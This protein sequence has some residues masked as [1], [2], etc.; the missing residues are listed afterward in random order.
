MANCTSC[1]TKRPLIEISSWRQVGNQLVCPDCA[2]RNDKATADP[3]G[4]ARAA[5]AAGARLLQISLSLSQTTGHAVAMTGTN[6]TTTSTQHTSTLEAIEAEGW[7]LEHA[8]YVYRVTGS[9]SRD[10]F[11]SSGQQEAVHG[12]VLGVYIFRVQ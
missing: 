3:V 11:L 10:K 7:R 8:A 4:Q 9:V 6:A 2:D 12:E 5:K 1:G